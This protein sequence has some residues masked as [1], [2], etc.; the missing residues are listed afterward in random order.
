MFLENQQSAVHFSFGYHTEETVPLFPKIESD[1]RKFFSPSSA[2]KNVFFEEALGGTESRVK[3]IMRFRNS[4][5][6]FVDAVLQELLLRESGLKPGDYHLFAQREVFQH[7]NPETAFGVAT[8]QML[9]RV[10]ADFNFDF[11]QEVLPPHEA[12]LTDQRF[13]LSSQKFVQAL[14]SA[15]AGENLDATLRLF[16][17][18]EKMTAEDSKLRNLRICE[19]LIDRLAKAQKLA[20]ETRI[21]VRL[22]EQ[23]DP[24]VEKLGSLTI[25]H[26][27]ISRPL[28]KISYDYCKPLRFPYEDLA[29]KM[30]IDPSYKPDRDTL[31]SAFVAGVIETHLL[32]KKVGRLER[33]R[34]GQ[35]VIQK[36]SLEELTRF[37]SSMA[38]PEVV[39]IVEEFILSKS[40]LNPATTQHKS[41][42][43]TAERKAGGG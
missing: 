26:R 37:I 32:M 14:R 25:N 23:H 8:Y 33:V 1:L 41:I 35:E 6:S 22:G 11:D 7:T 40:S 29:I 15:G 43:P 28:I 17:E 24:I 30:E 10:A 31:I 21:F 42:L 18:S 3:N 39:D 2:V 4:G 20:Q 13:S 38:S 5:S 12:K 36:T 9:D 34:I 19:R 27:R 16:Y